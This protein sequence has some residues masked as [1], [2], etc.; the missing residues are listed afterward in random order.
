[1]TGRERHPARRPAAHPAAPARVRTPRTAARLALAM[2]ALVLGIGSC[3][4]PQPHLPKLSVDAA[5]EGRP[6]GP[7]TRL[8]PAPGR[9]T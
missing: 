3:Q 9:A 1:M 4:L 8:A 5:E 6:A 7:V 2:G